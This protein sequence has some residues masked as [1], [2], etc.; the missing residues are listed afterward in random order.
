[1]A[2]QLTEKDI[3]GDILSS[4]KFNASGYLHAVIEAQDQVIRQTFL[5]YQNQCLASQEKIFRYMQDQ[6][7][8]RVP[9][10]KETMG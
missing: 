7:W 6:G 4:I 1:M 5:D 8:Y 3:A 2:Q 10:N 9:M